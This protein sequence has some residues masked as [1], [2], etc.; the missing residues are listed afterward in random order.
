M[1]LGKSTRTFGMT[2]AAGTL[3]LSTTS[4]AFA[5]ASA[6]GS[7]SSSCVRWSF[8]EQGTD[9]GVSAELDYTGDK[10]G[11]LRARATGVGAW[12]KFDVWQPK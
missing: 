9:R 3:V 11:V 12:E 1:I 4:T 7:L 8:K 5:S 10:K 6:A 2:L